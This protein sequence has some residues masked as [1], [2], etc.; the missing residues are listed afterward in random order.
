VKFLQQSRQESPAHDY[1]F[2]LR[3]EL[4]VPRSAPPIPTG[5]LAVCGENVKPSFPP[6]H[7]PGPIEFTDI[8]GVAG[9]NLLLINRE[10]VSD[11]DDWQ[12]IY[13]VNGRDL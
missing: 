5:D 9:S 8:T 6:V 2:L 1:E 12:K 3:T 11:V 10:I 7:S 13:L 4:L